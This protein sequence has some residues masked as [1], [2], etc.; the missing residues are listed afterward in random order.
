MGI[1]LSRLQEFAK[2]GTGGITYF[3]LNKKGSVRVRLI[4]DPFGDAENPVMLADRHW[5]PVIDATGKEQRKFSQCG[6]TLGDDEFCPFCHL[7]KLMYNS[8]DPA[9][10]EEARSLKAG[11]SYGMWVIDRTYL[12]NKGAEY[13]PE[14]EIPMLATF[15][16]S[17]FNT[18]IELAQGSHWGEGCF[19]LVDG[20]DLIITGSPKTGTSFS[21]YKVSPVPMSASPDVDINLLD[22][23]KCKALAEVFPVKPLDAQ[24]K[25]L[26]PI[27][28]S[29]TEYGNVG[30]SIVETFVEDISGLV[31]VESIFPSE[32]ETTSSAH[33]STN[34][35]KPTANTAK[36]S[37]STDE[38]KDTDMPTEV[39]NFRDA[40][41]EEEAG[42]ASIVTDGKE[43]KNSGTRN[44]LLNRLGKK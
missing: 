41:E 29:L 23:D 2:R 5:F 21:E 25:L 39:S 8:E 44:S 7:V 12:E 22:G 19:Y 10:Q 34:T 40:M 43:V 42:E 32:E 24:I 1:N 6:K 15:G 31:D 17:V 28:S 38:I 4:G 14:K 3:K 35:P 27:L 11:K 18:I 9:M 16:A 26:Q 33:T 20:Y 30:M 13:D 36:V 37:S